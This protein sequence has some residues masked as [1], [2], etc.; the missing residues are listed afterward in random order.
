[1]EDKKQV[2]ENIMEKHRKFKE[3]QFRRNHELQ[4]KQKIIIKQAQMNL[5]ELQHEEELIYE[6]CTRIE[7]IYNHLT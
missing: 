7:T 6:F 2:I 5:E 3:E 1:M 4:E